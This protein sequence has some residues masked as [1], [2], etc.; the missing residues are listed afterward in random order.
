MTCQVLAQINVG[1]R[2][3]IQV[4]IG[5]RVDREGV[6]AGVRRNLQAPSVAD[7]GAPPRLPSAFP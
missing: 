4:G 3:R 5:K 1:P 7:V 2:N 6:R